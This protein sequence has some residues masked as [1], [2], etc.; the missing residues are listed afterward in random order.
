[1]IMKA[2][3]PMLAPGLLLLLTGCGAA[4]RP[5]PIPAIAEQRQCPSYP[6]PPTDLL[7]PPIRTDFLNPTPSPRP[8]RRSS[9]MN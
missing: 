7:K 2:A 3:W 8:S 6:L 9:L 5:Q 1:M 4:P